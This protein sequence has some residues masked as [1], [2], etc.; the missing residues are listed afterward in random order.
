MASALQFHHLPRTAPIGAAH[1]DALFEG[2]T[3]SSPYFAGSRMTR[4][5]PQ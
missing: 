3:K 1:V 5:L 4:W 2:V